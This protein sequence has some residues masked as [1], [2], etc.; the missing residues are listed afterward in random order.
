MMH[1]ELAGGELVRYEFELS[2]PSNADFADLLN[3]LISDKVTV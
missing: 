3:L 1:D 2:E